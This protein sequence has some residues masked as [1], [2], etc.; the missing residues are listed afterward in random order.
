MN[1]KLITVVFSSMQRYESRLR[2][3][4]RCAQVIDSKR[5]ANVTLVYVD[6]IIRRIMT[7]VSLQLH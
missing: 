7:V 2:Q 6:S 3:W 1:K 5:S 4:R